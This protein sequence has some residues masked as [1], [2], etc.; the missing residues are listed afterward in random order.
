MRLISVRIRNY[1]VH[2]DVTV[3][4]D[5]AHT[6][7]GGPNESGKSTI[8]EAIH[9]ALFLRS[10]TT[11]A[12][13]KA[14]RSDLHPG[15]PTVELVFESGGSRHTITKQFTGTT[16]GTTAIKEEGGRTLHGEEAEER[17]HDLCQAEDVGGGK[18]LET[19]L[20]MQWAHLWVWQGTAGDDPVGHAND[21]TAR[22]HLREQ[23]GRLDAGNVLE[24]PLDGAVSRA[25]TDHCGR[26]F[27]DK[28]AAR[29]GSALAAA[30]EE[31]EAAR[32]ALAGATAA[33][34]TFAAA[35][36]DIDAADASIY[37]CDAQLKQSREELDGVRGRQ[38]E[39][40]GLG[41]QAAQRE[42]EAAAAAQAHDELVAADAEIARCA[43]RQAA[44]RRAIEP[45]ECELAGVR[46]A[47]TAGNERF[48]RAMEASGE[49]HRRQ[50]AIAGLVELHDLCEH[51]ERLKSER[52]G[53][54]GRCGRIAALRA[55]TARLQAALAALPALTADDVAGLDAIE[56]TR[57]A[58]RATLEAIATRIEVLAAGQPVSLDGRPLDTGC[59]E[60]IT[61]A[62]ELAVG[63]GTR[64][65][66]SP[67]GGRSLAEATSQYD[68]AAE[69]LAARLA[70]LAIDTVEAARH[71]QASRQSL[72]ADLKA[73][74]IAIAGLGG[75]EADRSLVNLDREIE[76]AANEI[77]RR[78][79]ADFVQPEGLVAAQE[80]RRDMDRR[81]RE[82]IDEAA[83]VHSELA[84]AKAAHDAAI[85][86]R[87]Q[88]EDAIRAN[89]EELRTVEERARL[90]VERFGA[91]RERAQG[92]AERARANN[93]AREGLAVV[94]K[95]LEALQPESLARDQSRLERA[96]ANLATRRHEAETSREVAR[97]RLQLG[98]TSDPRDDLA[99]ATVRQR[100]AE[101]GHARARREA[102]AVRLLV[103][104]FAEKRQEVEAQFVAPL[105]NRVTEYLRHLYGTDTQ[106]VIEYRDE[107]FQG[108]TVSRAGSGHTPFAFGQL[109]GGAREQVAAAFR[110][111]M[112]EILAAG[113]DGCLP[114]VFDDAFVN[115][116][117]QRL[118]AVQRLLDL[119]ASRGLQVIVLTCTPGDYSA[120]GASSVTIARS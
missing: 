2:A 19:R 21:G 43:D 90:L 99:R 14:M 13:A 48:Q 119:A 29:A 112:A 83:A 81:N 16:A 110:L 74:E 76:A 52:T 100:E 102:E 91:D 115:A 84:A 42:H 44:I 32:A 86:A 22:G 39:A 11:G 75:D 9:N 26:L 28:G 80:Q 60:T 95:R 62:A 3:Q 106:V 23:L 12:A 15:I 37:V 25:I 87:Q 116:D 114:V 33:V 61:A 54:A 49:A 88:A 94:R 66:I 10:R 105:A 17:I 35:V 65:R 103:D 53:L 118:Q 107:K 46:H 104:L 59:A 109:S 79:A 55:D 30:T 4:F 8:V 56:R 78:A 63:G 64:L 89:R 108:L 34:A 1:R 82:I 20:R 77:A 7:V 36:A 101:A 45:A 58:A 113:H 50:A 70:G 71:A 68:R 117:P 5:P 27:T 72:A 120:L 47:E 40:A 69:T 38:Q 111:A 67:G 6:V 92:I 24:S 98:G 96:A 93:E 31:L 57:D 41:V 51:L 18:G 85:Q 73:Q 97:A